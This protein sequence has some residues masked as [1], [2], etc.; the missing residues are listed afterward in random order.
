MK[1]LTIKTARRFLLLKQGLIGKRRFA[2]KRGALEYV[3]QA[4]CIQFDPVNVCGRNAELTLLARVSRF[5]KNMLDE[6]L[7]RDR[8]L[9]DY[10]DKELSILPVEDYPYFE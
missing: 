6:L 1:R 4:G 2:G 8:L 10:T 3:R 5:S 7:Y 9:F